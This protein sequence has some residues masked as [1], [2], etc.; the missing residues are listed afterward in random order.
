MM[1]IKDIVKAYKSL[2]K[3]IIFILS[4]S[5]TREKFLRSWLGLSS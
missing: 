1:G 4:Q 3:N 5:G 2:E